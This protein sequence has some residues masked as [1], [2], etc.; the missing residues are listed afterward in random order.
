[1]KI[2]LVFGVVAGLCAA[3]GLY[4]ILISLITT[5]YAPAKKAMRMRAPKQLTQT[6]I[7]QTELAR[8]LE[9]HISLDEVQK[10]QMASMLQNLDYMD[11]PELFYAQA[12]I[13]G[14]TVAILLSFLML[15]SLP[16]G[17]IASVAAGYGFFKSKIGSLAKEQNRKRSEIEK[18]L[19]QFASTIRQNLSQTRNMVE[20]FKSYRRICGKTLADEID[21]TVNDMMTGNAEQAIINFDHRVNSPKLTQVLNAVLAVMRG[22]DQRAQFD[23]MID[24][25]RKSQD[26]AVKRMLLAR[27]NKLNPYLGVLFLFLALMIAFSLGTDLAQSAG[28]LFN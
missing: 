5:V 15:L 1:M 6:Q 22:D 27:P 23:I 3:T 2:T 20:I 24:S 19:P 14:V 13:Q 11:S 26:E 16:I 18:E 4:L 28:T 25:F 10:V 12:V 9:P 21:R 8:K 17:L 7:I